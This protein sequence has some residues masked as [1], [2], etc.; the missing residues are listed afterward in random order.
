MT[1]PPRF[2]ELVSL[3]FDDA[4]D[5]GGLEELNVLLSTRPDLATRLVHLGRIHG[6]LRELEAG[7]AARELGPVR[8]R[9]WLAWAVPGVAAAAFLALVGLL[10]RPAARLEGVTGPVAFDGS[11][12]QTS[13]GGAAT[14]VL[15]GGAR[16]HAGGE[17][18]LRL[19]GGG[20]DVLR[21]TL[22][23]DVPAGRAAGLSLTTPEAQLRT[24]GA[25]FF[26]SVEL[27]S[28]LCRVEEGDVRMERR[29]TS[30][31]IDLR[32]GNY[33]LAGR[34]QEFKPVAASSPVPRPEAPQVRLLA[35]ARWPRSY[36]VAPFHVGS[37]LYRDRGWEITTIPAE[38]DGA[39]GIA[40]LAED[41]RSQEERL[42]VFEID[43]EADVWVG[44]DGRAAQLAKKLPSW[45]SG[46]EAT[47]LKIYSKTASNSY[48]HLY[49]K[50]FPAGEVALGGNHSGG[51]TGA[52][53]NYTVLVTP[54]R[55]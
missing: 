24:S 6:A 22:A 29:A 19:S 52:G 17:T 8:R 51:D 23:C 47:G 4:L 46:W 1:T 33:A 53:V 55:H 12:L 9:T 34:G 42:L 16:L 41:R 30:G 14:L 40:T 38:L 36:A 2:D 44:I 43:R 3:Y 5:A 32:A 15:P 48:Y 21:G 50:R 26:L 37:L 39:L 31:A 20:V 35:P 49:R 45:L 13:A 54:P 27:E 25:R 10:T 28:T 18:A 11:A 7:R